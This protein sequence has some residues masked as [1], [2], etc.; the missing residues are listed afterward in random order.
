MG[1]KIGIVSLNENPDYDILKIQK[2]Y[3]ILGRD[4]ST[5]GSETI[6]CINPIGSSTLYF[7]D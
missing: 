3:L 6:E 7:F 4:R 1:K 5:I 2:D